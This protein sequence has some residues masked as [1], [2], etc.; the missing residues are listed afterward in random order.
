[1]RKLILGTLIVLGTPVF[2][3]NQEVVGSANSARVTGS[4]FDRDARQTRELESL[5]KSQAIVNAEAK[6]SEAPGLFKVDRKG[7]WEI[8]VSFECD[9]M[10]YARLER[11]WVSV[12]ANF[13]CLSYKPGS[14][15]GLDLNLPSGQR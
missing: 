2:A 12:K 8:N 10:P 13:E 7:E 14:S 3:Q 11:V 9:A 6:C 5:S 15:F 1:M 4:C